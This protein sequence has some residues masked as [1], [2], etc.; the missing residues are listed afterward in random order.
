MKFPL[1]KSTASSKVV[2]LT[3][4]RGL[5]FVVVQGRGKPQKTIKLELTLFFANPI[6][7]GPRGAHLPR[8]S[9]RENMKRIIRFFLAGILLSS[10]LIGT[11]AVFAQ[12]DEL[13]Y[14]EGSPEIKAS[15]EYYKDINHWDIFV[16]P[17]TIEIIDTV[18]DDYGIKHGYFLNG[19][20]FAAVPK[21]SKYPKP[22]IETGRRSNW[23]KIP[24]EGKNID[25]FE[26]VRNAILPFDAKY[27]SSITTQTIF[28]DYMKYNFEEELNK[29][30]NTLSQYFQASYFYCFSYTSPRDKNQINNGINFTT[31]YKQS[32]RIEINNYVPDLVDNLPFYTPEYSKKSYLE[33]IFLTNNQKFQQIKNNVFLVDKYVISVTEKE[34]PVYSI[35]QEGNI[36]SYASIN[37]IDGD[38]LIDNRDYIIIDSN[39]I[40][41]Y[42]HQ[43][44]FYYDGDGAGEDYEWW[45]SLVVST[46]L[47]IDSL[48]Y[49]DKD[50][51][52]TIHFEKYTIDSMGNIHFIVSN[53]DTLSYHLEKGQIISDNSYYLYEETPENNDSFNYPI[54]QD[55]KELRI[56][57]KLAKC[58]KKRMK[59]LKKLYGENS[60]EDLLFVL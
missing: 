57:R 44:S 1:H 23:I 13:Y 4:L 51:I 31:L 54:K 15:C 39:T 35:G 46:G 12:D 17:Y 30:Y 38:T 32:D 5:Y 59:L 43:Y 24:V 58:N 20:Y 28:S 45:S 50:T 41:C 53:K 21:P 49:F 60:S 2:S 22:C 19:Y 7:P 11:N 6:L 55:N 25:Y 3:W 37:S 42:H 56:Q 14:H 47:T 8:K 27:S 40:C 16:E 18:Y 10:A 36:L 29:F 52:Y 34:C 26:Q 9:R 33:S 48:L